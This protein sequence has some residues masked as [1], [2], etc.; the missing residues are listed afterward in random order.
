MQIA[1]N[2][3][4]CQKAVEVCYWT[5]KF[6]RDCKD[7]H[8]AL[9]AEPGTEAIT[10]RLSE[11]AKKSGRAF[12]PQTM[13]LTSRS[14]KSTKKN[15]A[16]IVSKSSIAHLQAADFSMAR[17][18]AEFSDQGEPIPNNIFNNNFGEVK[19]TMTESNLDIPTTETNTTIES[20][21]GDSGKPAAAKT[22]K[23]KPV[24]KPKPAIPTS[25]PVFLLLYSN[26]KYKELHESELNTE[27][28]DV[29]KDPSLRLVKG[30]TLIPQISFKSADE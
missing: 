5:C 9:V 21:G 11:A 8:N 10:E 23:P 16:A 15:R 1:C 26:G 4:S 3:F 2:R 13:V 20:S 18:E 12:D 7:W 30:L 29:L 14:K 25:G 6:R 17:G 27:A 24:A 22:A 19:E 28:A